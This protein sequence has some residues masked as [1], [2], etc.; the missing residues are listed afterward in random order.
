MTAK[1]ATRQSSQNE[2]QRISVTRMASSMSTRFFSRLMV[3]CGELNIRLCI[4][5]D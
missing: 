4:I 2:F 5:G 3:D 1:I